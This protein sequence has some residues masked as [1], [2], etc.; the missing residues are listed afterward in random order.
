MDSNDTVSSDCALCGERPRREDSHI[1][2]A[3]AFRWMKKTSATGFMRK[4]NNP[5]RRTQDGAKYPLLCEECEDRLSVH[6]NQ[7]AKQI[8]YPYVNEKPQ[9]MP[10]DHHCMLFCVSVLWR[11]LHCL[12]IDDEAIEPLQPEFKGRLEKPYQV[13]SDFLLGREKHPK[14]FCVN[15]VPV[16]DVMK[17]E[18][19]VRV[20][21]ISQYFTGSIDMDLVCNA[22]AGYVYAKIP[23][24]LIF[25]RV[26]DRTS[27][28]FSKNTLIRLRKGKLGGSKMRPQPD[29]WH[30]VID[31][32]AWVQQHVHANLSA[33]QKK[34]IADTVAKNPGKA[35]QSRSSKSAQADMNLNGM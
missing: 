18:G 35:S 14:E 4:A 34:A 23:H 16:D 8:F 32:A 19:D 28:S 29:L 3:F 10:Y 6:E 30:Y 13:W 2:P 12:W 11:V 15:V 24:F 33:E 5:N 25:G 31:R 21:G 1:I 27:D 22:K 20:S 26:Y 9:V 17:V 7:F